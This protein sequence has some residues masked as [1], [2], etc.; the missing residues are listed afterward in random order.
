GEDGQ[1]HGR[2]GPTSSDVGISRR[3]RPGTGNGTLGFLDAPVPG[4]SSID[5][6]DTVPRLCSR[7]S[8]YGNSGM[9]AALLQKVRWLWGPE[10][11]PQLRALLQLD[12]ATREA[13]L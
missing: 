11:M 6:Q 13:A 3:H 4:L 5:R 9:P 10:V 7:A 8:S 12:G 2:I 1:R